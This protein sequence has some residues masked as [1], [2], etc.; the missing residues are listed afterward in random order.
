MHG[1][2]NI[3]NSPLS[4]VIFKMIFHNFSTFKKTIYSK[5]IDSQS[6]WISRIASKSLSDYARSCFKSIAHKVVK[7][8][9]LLKIKRVFDYCN[10][11]VH[12][13]MFFC[14]ETFRSSAQAI[15]QR[16]RSSAWEGSEGNL[17]WLM[18]NLF[19]DVTSTIV[20]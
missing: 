14:T 12:Q 4:F 6:F 10:M 7:N 2:Q 9:I 3:N 16:T 17:L 20:L 1:Q 11:S 18:G 15:K 5:E 13:H 19:N 8:G